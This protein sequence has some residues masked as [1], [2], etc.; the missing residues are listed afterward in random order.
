MGP[1]NPV[2]VANGPA[3]NYTD[4]LG[5]PKSINREHNRFYRWNIPDFVYSFDASF[6][7]YFGPEGI[8]AVDEAMTVINDFFDPT[9]GSY[10]GMSQLDLEKHGF[11]GNYNTTWINTTAQN[12]QVIDIKSI[13]LGMMVNHLGL[14]NPHRH[15]FSIVGT[16]PNASSNVLNISVA[17]TGDGTLS[18]QWQKNG[19]NI[20]GATATT[21]SL[22]NVANSD[23][24]AYRC[25]VTHV[26]GTLSSNNGDLTV[27]NP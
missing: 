2:E 15:A 17:A 19:V 14:G 26:H 21:Y 1:G 23:S 9:D 18:Y 4:D 8:T 27:N 24:G 11:T 16:A 7:N 6:A 25:I 3:W 22:T 5:A 12:A 10:D 20:A 13:V